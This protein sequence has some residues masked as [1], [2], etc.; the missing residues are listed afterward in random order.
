MIGF[1]CRRNIVAIEELEKQESGICA[2]LYNQFGIT[3]FGRYPQ[4]LLVSQDYQ[5]RDKNFLTYG[6]ILY[7]GADNP[8]P[9]YYQDHKLLRD[10]QKSITNFGIIP[11]VFEFNTKQE[12]VKHL[13]RFK[14]GAKNKA[15]FVLVG[16]H[17]SEAGELFFGRELSSRSQ[18]HRL[19][20][21]DTRD[22]RFETTLSSFLKDHATV[23]FHSCFAGKTGGLGQ[24]VSKLG[25]D[26]IGPDR[27]THLSQVT[28][29]AT[30]EGVKFAADYGYA[31]TLHYEDGKRVPPYK[32]WF[33]SVK[34]KLEERF[35][36]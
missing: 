34:R 11:F 6:L 14:R 8:S 13:S 7:P 1:N 31:K 16:G 30:E 26:V 29:H 20:P 5:S 23:I 27:E 21:E 33:R 36:T 9:A 2:R 15:N 28:A 18:E 12:L 4:D 35:A 17:G 32:L 10:F 19:T 24:Q 22:P 3:S 25:Y